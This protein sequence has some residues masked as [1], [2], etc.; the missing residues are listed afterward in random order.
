VNEPPVNLPTHGDF[1]AKQVL[2]ADDSVAILDLDEAVRGDPAADLGNFVAHLERDALRGTLP[3]SR[4]ELLQNALLEGYRVATHRPI[5]ARTEL[6]AA[7]GLLRLAPDPF[8]HREPDWPGR[9]EAIL[10]R[11]E[12]ILDGG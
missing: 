3:S 2:L 12:A 1:Y 8:R 9:I 4:V 5:P 7:A 10:E 11:T 6:Y